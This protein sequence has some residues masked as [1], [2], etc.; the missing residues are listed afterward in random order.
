MAK[1]T[2]IAALGEMAKGGG[3]YFGAVNAQKVKAE[4]LAEARAER[5]AERKE[6]REYAELQYQQRRGDR[7]EDAVA[8]QE[9]LDTYES[10]NP[11]Y[12][13]LVK[14][15]DGQYYRESSNGELTETGLEFDRNEGVPVASRMTRD[16][17]KDLAQEM[18]AIKYLD[19][20][21]AITKMRNAV[22]SGNHMSDTAMI[23]YFMKTLDPTSVVRESEFRTVKDARAFLTRA[24]EDG[25]PVPTRVV[26]LIQSL[27]GKGF[28][29]PEMRQQ[30]LH[31]SEGAFA[32]KQKNADAIARSYRVSAEK[33]QLDPIEVGFHKYQ[34]G[35]SQEAAPL[36]TETQNRISDV[37][38]FNFLQ[39]NE[40]DG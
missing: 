20:K 5:R 14:A 6:D 26:Q 31:E 35:N 23:F 38:V 2:A 9:A 29:T 12:K 13:G 27:E 39:Q 16:L 22:D 10:E 34:S 40:G 33:Y 18:K 30:I 36:P 37:D 7:V 24:E 1:W 28:L 21:E 25:I 19:A 3:S 15:A 32:S 11:T 4:R 8:Q 17:R